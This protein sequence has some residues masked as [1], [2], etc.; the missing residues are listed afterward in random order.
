[1]TNAQVLE[2]E[3]PLAVLQGLAERL[4]GGRG[5]LALVHGEAGIGKT[6][7]LTAFARAEKPRHQFL[8]GWSES[9]SLP[10]PLGPLHDM[11]GSLGADVQ[12]LL[13]NGGGQDRLFRTILTKTEETPAPIVMIFE[14]VHWADAATLDLIKFIGRRI[15]H[16]RLLLILSGRSDELG[17]MHPVTQVLGDLPVSTTTRIALKPLS[18]DAVTDLARDA[19]IGR[20][21]HSI[22]SGNP[23]FVTELLN[24]R[25]DGYAEIPTTVSDAVW[26]RLSRL[27]DAA[28]KAIELMSLVP[29]GI[30]L[31]LLQDCLG[32]DAD[33]IVGTCLQKGMGLIDGMGNFI[34]RHELMR[35]AI[36]NRLQPHQQ[37]ALHKRLLE[38]MEAAEP[39][40]ALARLVHHASSAHDGQKVLALAPAAA[41]EAARMGAH[42]QAAFHLSQALEY[43]DQAPDELIAQMNGDWAYEAGLSIGINDETIAARYRAIAIWERL[44]R[45]EKVALNYR[46]LSRMHWYL[47]RSSESMQ[48]LD[49]AIKALDGV[50]PGAELAWVLS[51]ISQMNMLHDRMDEAIK[52]G[53]DAIAVARGHD[54][55]EVEA[56]SLCNIAS[57]MLFT[58]DEAGEL[59]MQHSLEISLAHEFH[60]Q[61]ARAYTNFSEYGITTRRFDLAEEILTAG[62]AFDTKHDLDAWTH[63]LIGRK[64]QLR[65]EQGRL[66]EAIAMTENVL[67]IK[68]LTL[69]MRLPS[70]CVLAKS[71][72]RIG[73][74]DAAELLDKALKDVLLTGE[75]QNIFPTRLARIEH[76]W[77]RG[78]QKPC[79]DELDA[80]LKMNISVCDPFEAGDIAV[81]AMRTGTPM[82]ERLNVSALAPARR[83][84]LEGDAAGAARIWLDLGLPFEAALSLLSVQ[85]DASPD[86]LHQALRL[87][88]DLQAKP[89]VTLVLARAKA[90]GIKIRQGRS[91][92]YSAVRAHPLGLTRREAEV[93]SLVAGGMTNLEIAN[94]LN[95]SERTVE[96]HVSAVL[97]KMD[98]PN[99]MALMLQL[100]DE[101]WLVAMG[102]SSKK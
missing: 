54:V 3:E 15:L 29:G 61:A 11:A 5:G 82:D 25:V 35:L 28:R 49:K 60:E 59:L 41:A 32:K 20:E 83:A 30:E 42:L 26:A 69:V 27:D 94:T 92:P 58:G 36:M 84:E 2:R 46:W 78:D 37:I 102:Q 68:H 99:R 88:T 93:L 66:T 12:D 73:R 95:R 14:D 8:W 74:P 10:R 71:C 18:E 24:N 63:Y 89:A 80:L 13:D 33:K 64:A 53:N 52:W 97:G 98:K 91:G 65:M 79:C 40:V 70:L 56:H 51:S 7:L 67:A 72:S 87:L 50:P 9:L 76:F 34:F 62:I 4:R 17:P 38:V 39:P 100:R 23:F 22:T 44:G 90:S 57:A 6:T 81:W 31:R 101:P 19:E 77:I 75:P 48:F 85:G 1:M 43:V 55:P 86:A 21:V 47:G 16:S 45:P 96:H